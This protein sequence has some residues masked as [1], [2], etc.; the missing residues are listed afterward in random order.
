MDISKSSYNL[1]I[2]QKD[3]KSLNNQNS[4][5][6][7]LK[8][9]KHLSYEQLLFKI[10]T[11]NTKGLDPEEVKLAETS[12][13]F[14]ALFIKQVL[15][16]LRKGLDTNTLFGGNNQEYSF[17]SDM[18]YDNYSKEMAEQSSGFGMGKMLFEQVKELEKQQLIPNNRLPSLDLEA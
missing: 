18:L 8:E 14:E 10:K 4:E 5:N 16:N 15:T 1:N 17:Y 7:S 11:N 12:R 13:D 6:K 3:D 9:N 2:A